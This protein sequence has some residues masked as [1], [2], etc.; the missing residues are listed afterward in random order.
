LQIQLQQR[1]EDAVERQSAH[2][3][4]RHEVLETHFSLLDAKA[5]YHDH[6]ADVEQ[7]RQAR[8]KERDAGILRKKQERAK[9][10]D[11][12]RR[13]SYSRAQEQ[14]A[15]RVA[16]KQAQLADQDERSNRHLELVNGLSMEK[17]RNL[18]ARFQLIQDAV[19]DA[20]NEKAA[21]A[22]AYDDRLKNK[23]ERS[24][25]HIEFRQVCLSEQQL[26]RFTKLDEH[27]HQVARVGKLKE[28]YRSLKQAEYI[29]DSA[30][31]GQCQD[32]KDD[33]KSTLAFNASINPQVVLPTC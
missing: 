4:H 29:T 19:V 32:L 6:K 5:A 26:R 25:S 9:S 16:N 10:R 17:C 24:K 8:V 18:G 7:E 22:Q 12:Q 27:E 2:R 30:I 23:L 13:L 31:F 33:M 14:E 21:K 28:F 20:N 11:C 15:T 1:L 3:N